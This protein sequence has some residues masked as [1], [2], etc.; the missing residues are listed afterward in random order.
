MPRLVEVDEIPM[1]TSSG[2]RL[3]PVDQVPQAKGFGAQLDDLIN[4][5]PTQLGLGVRNM[6]RGA[7]AP[8]DLLTSPIRNTLNAGLRA[9]Q[10]SGSPFQFAPIS[11][12]AI[13]DDI[14]LPRPRNAGE[15]IAGDAVSAL[16]GA[17][18]PI[19]VGAQ[20]A[21]RAG[22]VAQG[23][24]RMLAARP[25]TQLAS[26][27][28]SGVAGGAARETGGSQNAQ[29][30]ASLGA[31]LLTPAGLAL[32][33]RAGQAAA[34]AVMPRAAPAPIQVELTI[35]NAL[36]GQDG[37]GFT[38]GDLPGDVANT[39][40][41]DVAQAMSIG[42]E[43]SP[44]AVRRLADFRLT[45]LTP[46][47]ASLTLD[48]V[49]VTRQK[50][51]ANISAT[52]KDPNAQILARTENAN[53][54][55]MT[56]YLND[57]GAATTDDPIAGSTKVINALNARNDAEQAVINQGYAKARSADGRSALL[58]DQSF[59]NDAMA[60]LDEALV[61]WKVPRT[62]SS[63]LEK[64][65]NGDTPL[66]VDN[67][68]ML[69]SQLAE[70]SR[71]SN[72]GI[73]Q[74]A[75]GLI[76]G[77]LESTPLKPGQNIGQ[78]A[79]DAFNEARALHRNWMEVVDKTPALQAV[80]A[81]VEP[82]RFVE[83]FIVGRGPKSDVMDVAMLRNAIQ[84]SPEA[85]DAVRQQIAAY[86]KNSAKGGKADEIV[87][88]GQ[89]GYNRALKNIGDR[90]LQLFFRPEEVNQLKAL[91][92]VAEYE[93]FQPAG[94][95]V[96]NSRTDAGINSV[97]ENI[98][99]SPLVSKIPFGRQIVGDPGQALIIGSQAKTTLN[100]PKSLLTGVPL[101]PPNAAS[102]R[103]QFAPAGIPAGLLA[104]LYQDDQKR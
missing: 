23:V 13:A 22:G 57:L 74:K 67:A 36:A 19:G 51:L 79:V 97:I 6:L 50:N 101:A 3:V 44:D 86:L 21:Q 7:A 5:A 34:R 54:A 91:G 63:V 103:S 55:Q 90:K 18:L 70:L 87:N 49:D 52:S 60:A 53:N 58:D 81:G 104:P 38:L 77:A 46:T 31:G 93:Q 33:Q 98:V 24:G 76:R 39:L 71:L 94:S 68:E 32:G 99:N 75:L 27:A 16:T 14:G 29:L 61:T 25:A 65:R 28:A 80:R 8:L 17:L 48:P 20:L 30:A 4:D 26:A 100:A 85:M 1:K 43:L 9:V 15:R 56:R 62:V 82:D 83:Q 88:F 72:N 42:Q 69:K 2:A 35:N 95:K 37:P 89:S 92:R 84:T 10:S 96:N 12:D 66:T 47:R 40:R 102:L 41:Q 73:E 45:G 11:G 59:V 64:I 78:K